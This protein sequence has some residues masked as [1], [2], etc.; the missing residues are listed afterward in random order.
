MAE[1]VYILCM[2][3]SLACAL[4]LF[5]GFRRSRARLLLWSS[6]CFIGLTANNALLFAD[7]VVF[8]EVDLSLWRSMT[9]LVGLLLLIY[10][11]V[12]DAE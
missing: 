6:V 11:L 10:G 7:K 9:A 2:L 8:P 5:R 4:L 1:A 12:W 3:A